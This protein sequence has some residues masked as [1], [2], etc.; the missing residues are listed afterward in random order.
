ME[1]LS[2]M[3]C[4]YVGLITSISIIVFLEIFKTLDKRLLGAFT[5]AGIAFIYLGFA[6]TDTQSLIITI[7][8]VALFLVLSYFGYKENFNFIIAGLVLHG[9]WDILFPLFSTTAPKGY[10]VF[11]VTV[12]LLL[13][14]YFFVRVKPIRIETI[15]YKKR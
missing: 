14:M 11:C 1:G 9:L 6:W 15:N 8:G 3:D 2:N 12:D 13:P 10:D 5:L 7:F 4:F